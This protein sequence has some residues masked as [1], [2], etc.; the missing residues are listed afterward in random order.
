MPIIPIQRVVSSTTNTV[1][2]IDR[3]TAVSNLLAGS[4]SNVVNVGNIGGYPEIVKYTNDNNTAFGGTTDPQIIWSQ[5]PTVSGES[6]GFAV[7]SDLIP[8]SVGII[9]SFLISLA[10]FCDNAHLSRIQIVNDLGVFLVPQ[11]TGLD[12]DL[13]DGSLNIFTAE[14][15]PYNWQRVRYYTIP[16]SLGT[17]TAATNVRFVFSFSAVNYNIDPSLPNPAGL[18]F[19][20]DI[21]SDFS[22]TT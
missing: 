16:V 7:Q 6:H 21:Y 15:L 20:A 8:L 19:I 22:I 9:N 5:I 2:A 11:P 18:A 17:I 10:V 3:A 13:L 12:V 1:A 4:S 14:T